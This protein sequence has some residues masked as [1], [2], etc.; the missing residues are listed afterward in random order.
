MRT[1][2][3]ISLSRLYRSEEAGKNIILTH[4][5]FRDPDLFQFGFIKSCSCGKRRLAGRRGNCVISDIRKRRRCWSF[6]QVKRWHLRLQK[7]RPILR[8][9]LLGFFS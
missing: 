5:L 4:D 9:Q 3:G 1:C 2:L 8:G 7:L 6:V